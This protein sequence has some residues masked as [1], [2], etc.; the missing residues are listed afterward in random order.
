MQKIERNKKHRR[1]CNIDI[2]GKIYNNSVLLSDILY[3]ATHIYFRH[4][5]TGFIYNNNIYNCEGEKIH[6]IIKTSG[7]CYLLRNNAT[8]TDIINTYLLGNMS[9]K[10]LN[11][12]GCSFNGKYFKI[13][14]EKDWEVKICL[15]G[16]P[17]KNITINNNTTITQLLKDLEYN[18]LNTS[19]F[20]R[21][22]KIC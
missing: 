3:R 6:K 10:L 16:Y 1:L 17:F 14:N 22:Y 11:Y 9:F 15:M 20:M 18:I 19:T 21:R 13:L 12:K 4:D 2:D 8:I 5:R 7:S